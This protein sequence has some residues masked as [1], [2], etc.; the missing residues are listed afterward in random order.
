TRLTTQTYTEIQMFKNFLVVLRDVM[1]I[2]AEF[3]IEEGSG[4]QEIVMKPGVVRPYAD[5]KNDIANQLSGLPS[6]TA[7]VKI[8]TNAPQNPGKKCLSCGQQSNSG[9]KYC[10]GCGTKIT[11]ANEYIITTLAPGQGIGKT[12]L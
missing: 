10:Q 1:R 5:V 12:T 8:G 2:L 4:R 6:F 11:A 3:P 9:A 7:R